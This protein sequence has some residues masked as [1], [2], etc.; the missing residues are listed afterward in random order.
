MIKI[1]LVYKITMLIL[2]FLLGLAFGS[3]A[4]VLIYRIPKKLSIIYPFSFCPSC[5]NNI[6]W[7]DNIPLVSYV[8]L[9][10]K[11]RVC[12]EGI[13]LVYP[14][15][16]LLCGLLSVLS[17]LRFGLTYAVI[18]FHFLFI[19]VV[20][21]MIDIQTTEIPDELS[22]YL[23]ASGILTSPFNFVVGKETFTRITNSLIGGLSGFVL[24]LTILIIGQKIFNKPVLGGGDVK[25]MCGIG[26]YLGTYA[27]FKIL[28]LASLIAS[29]YV[30][31]LSIIKRRKLLGQYIQ[32]APFISVGCAIH[33]FAFNKLL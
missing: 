13:S 20:I 7:Y 26:C 9:N 21:S 25:L 12:G 24:L 10:G 15:V 18:P 1:I 33:L 22:Y 31:F 23:I 2:S 8:L 14:T 27:V 11:C 19:L 28:F 32:Y 30:V 16:E 6:R 4:N 29:G 5:R 17:Y 3:F